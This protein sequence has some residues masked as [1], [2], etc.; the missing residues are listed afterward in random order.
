MATCPY[1][2]AEMSDEVKVFRLTPRQ[3]AVYEAVLEHGPLGIG[4]EYIM[5]NFFRDKSPTTARTC[6]YHINKIIRPMRIRSR[7]KGYFISED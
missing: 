6:I 7:G 3:R 2:K 4:H 5:T 1:C